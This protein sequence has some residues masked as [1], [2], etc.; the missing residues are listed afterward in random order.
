MQLLNLRTLLTIIIVFLSS[1]T[2]A[3]SQS[4]TFSRL[5]IFGDSL[6]DVGNTSKLFYGI[7]PGS[8]SYYNGHF[9]NGSVWVESFSKQ[10]NFPPELVINFAFA[11]ARAL[12]DFL[13]IP[14]LDQQ[15]AQ[16]IKWNN[17]GADPNALYV[18]WIGSNDIM[19]DEYICNNIKIVKKIS[20][21]VK[22]QIKILIKHGAQTFLIP[23]IPALSVTPLALE[24]D[25]K[26]HDT[27]YSAHL[28]E[29]TINYNNLLA[30][31]LNQLLIEYPHIKFIKFDSYNMLKNAASYVED[32]GIT[33]IHQRC[34]PNWY[35]YNFYPTCNNPNKYLFWDSVHPSAIGHKMLSTFITNSIYY[36]GYT[37]IDYDYIVTI[38]D[39]YIFRNNNLALQELTA[40]KLNF[41][42]QE[43]ILRYRFLF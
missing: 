8:P 6:S 30:N 4:Q 5:F 41:I 23:N 33:N 32:F 2:L 10:L 29:M 24:H 40:H 27:A 3:L 18:V 38:Q 26:H 35:L 43:P 1:N 20:D 21:H 13:P 34:N 12:K 37:P 9:S 17:T 19:N 14:S 39:R 7:L 16:Y 25:A 36:A 22:E 11:G 15:V 28:D 42:E 31:N